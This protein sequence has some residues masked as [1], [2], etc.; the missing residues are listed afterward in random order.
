MRESK[1]KVP[2]QLF[3]NKQAVQS[4]IITFENSV[5]NN[6]MNK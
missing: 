2:S 4:K 5:T 1:D 6:I 3:T